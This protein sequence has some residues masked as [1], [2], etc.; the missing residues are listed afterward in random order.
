MTGV[1]IGTGW[2]DWNR[3]ERL[4]QG[5]E[6]GTG[7]RDWNRLERLEQ[8][9]NGNRVKRWN[10]VEVETDWNRVEEGEEMVEQGWRD[11]NR[12]EQGRIG[13]GWRDWNRVE[14]LEQGG[15][16]GTGWRDWNRLERL[17]QG[18]NGNRVKRLEQGGEIGTGWR[19]WNRL[20]R[21][22]QG[23]EIGTGWRDWNRFLQKL[24][25]ASV[26]HFLLHPAALKYPQCHFLSLGLASLLHFSDKNV[27][28]P[29]WL[30]PGQRRSVLFN[31]FG[32]L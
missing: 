24:F 20:E 18:G 2:R 26:V 1:E 7:W 27:S 23:G 29:A 28:R 25:S 17:E 3:L 22:E 16:I 31:T 30:H 13:T 12:V 19:D 11:W 6:M 14:R 5:G 8:G 21:L 32:Y 15:E 4:E 9:G 10:R